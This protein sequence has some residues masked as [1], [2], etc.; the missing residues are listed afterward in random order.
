MIITAFSEIVYILHN[1]L[2]VNL[3]LLNDNFNFD[4]AEQN[5]MHSQAVQNKDAD[6]LQ[7][8]FDQCPDEERYYNC[9]FT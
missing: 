8:L 5:M 2:S 4:T 3:K 6:E 9:S 7:R 1:Y